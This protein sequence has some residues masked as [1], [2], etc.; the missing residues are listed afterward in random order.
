MSGLMF[1]SR[2]VRWRNLPP[3]MATARRGVAKLI[4]HFI[5]RLFCTLADV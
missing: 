1:A 2:Q 5:D 3:G 4:F